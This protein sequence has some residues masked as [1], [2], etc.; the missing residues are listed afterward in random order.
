MNTTRAYGIDPTN[1]EDLTNAELRCREQIKLFMKFF[2]EKIPGFEAAVVLETGAHIGVRESRHIRGEY[3]LSAE[4]FNRRF[5]DAIWGH[6]CSWCKGWDMHDPDG[7]AGDLSR[8]VNS[9]PMKKY[10]F[11]VPYRCLVTLKIDRLLVAGRCISAI[12]IM[13]WQTRSIESC[14]YTGQS[15]GTAAAISIQSGVLPR[16]VDVKK[17]QRKLVEQ[18]YYLSDTSLSFKDVADLA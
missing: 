1:G 18:G 11:Q 16:N 6:K 3:V 10:D 4:D 17:V 15:T 2:R 12:E 8:M 9:H 13:R 5:E 14:F 7:P